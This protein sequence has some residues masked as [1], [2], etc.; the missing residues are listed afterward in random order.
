MATGCAVWVLPI[1]C[2]CVGLWTGAT[3]DQARASIDR[4]RVFHRSAGAVAHHTNGFASLAASIDST[5]H[6]SR[7]S[8]RLFRLSHFNRSCQSNRIQC[9]AL[10]GNPV[11]YLPADPHH[12]PIIY[13]GL[14]PSFGGRA[15]HYTFTIADRLFLT[16]HCPFE[17]SGQ[18]SAVALPTLAQLLQQWE[19]NKL[20]PFP[21]ECSAAAVIAFLA[22]DTQIS[23]QL[24]LH[25]MAY[26]AQAEPVGDTKKDFD[27]ED[28]IGPRVVS[29][30]SVVH[31]LASTR[32]VVALRRC[33]DAGLSP[34][35]STA[36]GFSPLHH[37]AWRGSIEVV[38]EL[39]KSP[40]VMQRINAMDS[41]GATALDVA[42]HCGRTDVFSLLLARG[43]VLRRAQPMFN[44]PDSSENRQLIAGLREAVV[45]LFAADPTDF[46]A[47]VN[48]SLMTAPSGD[49]QLPHGVSFTQR[50]LLLEALQLRPY[51]AFALDL[52]ARSMRPYETIKMRDGRT[53]TR[54]R[55][56]TLLDKLQVA[57]RASLRIEI[58]ATTSRISPLPS[59]V[60]HHAS[61]P[62]ATRR[63]N[64]LPQ[65]PNVYDNFAK[66]PIG[67]VSLP[68]S[69]CLVD[70]QGRILV[71]L[72]Q[73]SWHLIGFSGSLP[74]LGSTS[75]PEGAMSE[76]DAIARLSALD[77]T[78]AQWLNAELRVCPV[79][80]HR[81]NRIS[82][83][84]LV[85]AHFLSVFWE[86]PAR[87]QAD[88]TT[89]YSQLQWTRPSAAG[90]APY[91]VSTMAA[92]ELEPLIQFMTSGT[93][94]SSPTS[95]PMLSPSLAQS[96]TIVPTYVHVAAPMPVPVSSMYPSTMYSTPPATTSMQPLSM[97]GTMYS[98]PQMAMP[99]PTTQ[100]RAPS[101]LPQPVPGMMYSGA[102]SPSIPGIQ[103]A[104]AQTAQPAAMPNHPA[105]SVMQMIQ[106]MPGMSTVPG[107]PV[108]PGMP[109]MPG[110]PGIPTIAPTP[111]AAAGIA[112][113]P[114]PVDFAAAAAM[115]QLP[116]KAA[117][118]GAAAAA[119]GAPPPL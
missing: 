107:M 111:A 15:S 19:V 52:L 51:S 59:P 45:L 102:P 2:S 87:H 109:P 81:A 4:Q 115:Q 20:G 44:V 70:P 76:L 13:L 60:Q 11:T 18:H 108:M 62:A 94:S 5:S 38:L 71:G 119:R 61:S 66:L 48:L 28:A 73:S 29:S 16:I 9:V 79:V 78:A 63:N 93:A 6:N 27:D 53:T 54:E 43:A 50:Q 99:S 95:T 26:A 25:F 97:S 67:A 116:A 33:I 117:G 112:A 82:L 100:P 1:L 14:D 42:V 12:S 74:V 77:S 96:G 40:L 49:V 101:P 41:F 34:T 58:P 105:M 10:H 69:V 57:S 37:A 113:P 114:I 103:V 85:P 88:P 8:C 80:V 39:L 31:V 56:L 91:S 98:S 75:G 22:G 21:Y 84:V 7:T 104:P 86:L 65:L 35:A 110:L 17:Y 46:D 30:A 47:I 24:D 55:V 64:P 83:V 92:A 36:L 106:K 72:R 118:P 32:H 3:K 23:A 90:F 68:A 89:G